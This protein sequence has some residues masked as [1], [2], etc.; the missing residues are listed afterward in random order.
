MGESSKDSFTYIETHQF[1]DKWRTSVISVTGIF[2][3]STHENAQALMTNF[4]H[5]KIQITHY[6]GFVMQ[7]TPILA[8]TCFKC[9]L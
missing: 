9:Y 5:C 1:S 3:Q 7:N 2:L 4:L 6:Y 8:N